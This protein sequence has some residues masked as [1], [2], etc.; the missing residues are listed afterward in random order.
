MSNHL[1]MLEEL[2]NL[3]SGL[4]QWEMEFIES[5]SNWDGVFTGKQA[6]TLTKIYDKLC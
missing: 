3:E 2:L 6:E 5:L 4:S 1:D